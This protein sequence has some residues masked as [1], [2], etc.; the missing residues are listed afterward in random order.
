MQKKRI[1]GQA[2]SKAVERIGSLSAHTI[3]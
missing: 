2:F 3:E 1:R